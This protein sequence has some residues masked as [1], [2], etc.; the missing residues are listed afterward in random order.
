MSTSG[1][2]ETRHQTFH[3]P[4][5]FGGDNNGV[6]NNVL[7]DPRTKAMLETFSEKAPEFAALLKRSLRDGFIS[8]DVAQAL[9]LAAENI[10][11]DVARALLVAGENI[12]EDV[13]DHLWNAGRDIKE[14]V[15]ETFPAVNRQLTERVEEINAATESLRVMLAQSSTHAGTVPRTPVVAVPRRTPEGVVQSSRRTLDTWRVRFGLMCGSSAAGLVAAI[16]LMR[17]DLGGQAIF[18]TVVMVVAAVALLV[19]TRR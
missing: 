13:A 12:N 8:P 9:L 2:D 1:Q 6:I 19:K 18:V 17:S 5:S 14:V 7:L 10:N 4:G 11:E 16:I 3:G 15:Q